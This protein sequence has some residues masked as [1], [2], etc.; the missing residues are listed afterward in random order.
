[1]QVLQLKADARSVAAQWWRHSLAFAAMALGL[2]YNIQPI[3]FWIHAHTSLSRP[4][5]SLVALISITLLPV[6][7]TKFSLRR[8]LQ[9]IALP[10]Y[11]MLFIFCYAIVR[12]FLQDAMASQ[13]LM[14]MG[15]GAAVYVLARFIGYW[16]FRIFLAAFLVCTVF[17]MMITIPEILS[18]LRSSQYMERIVLYGEIIANRWPSVAIGG[19]IAASLALIQTETKGYKT[20]LLAIL[21]GV[22]CWLP[23]FSG[24]RS[25]VVS[26]IITMVVTFAL[27]PRC[28]KRKATIFLMVFTVAATGFTLL[29]EKRLALYKQPA[30]TMQSIPIPT[31]KA[32]HY[33]NQQAAVPESFTVVSSGEEPDKN[34]CIVKGNS[35]LLRKIMIMDGIRA[36]STHPV[37]GIGVDRYQ[38]FTC[39]RT[40]EQII[41]ADDPH[42][43][44]L[45][46]AAELGIV[47][48]IPFVFI[49]C[50]IVSH[51]AAMEQRSRLL[52]PCF[53][54][55][56][57]QLVYDQFNTSYISA[58]NYYLVTGAIVGL[59]THMRHARR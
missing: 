1:M 21:V 58:T 2:L 19:M 28:Y 18:H 26:I 36:F 30:T 37:F 31:D 16:N 20:Y 11:A 23:L 9:S 56:L 42:V 15:S 47:G 41:P 12:L 45:H 48:L 34:T 40:T 4:F 17:S 22:V 59:L 10:D 54:L 57:F 35:I 5:F 44:T 29:P 6:C 8:T 50:W 55:W 51:I 7:L 24:T 27:C 25:V 43:S 53:A 52:L 46:V 39:V 32:G 14:L 33:T 49:I 38:S 3:F 13:N